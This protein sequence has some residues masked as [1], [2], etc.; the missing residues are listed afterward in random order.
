MMKSKLSFVSYDEIYDLYINKDLSFEE[1]SKIFNVSNSSISRLCKKYGIHKEVI[2]PKRKI[3]KLNRPGKNNKYTKVSKDDLIEYY[4]NQNKTIA[5]VAKILNFAKCVIE[6][7]L[8]FNNIHKTTEDKIK[9]HKQ[10][11]LKKY[12]VDSFSKT[13]EF[14]EKIKQTHLKNCGYESNFQDPAFKERV[15]KQ[16]LEKYGV[17]NV[18][19]LPE[20][21]EKRKQTCLKRYGVDNVIKLKE[22][23]KKAQKTCLKKYGVDSF[24]KTKEFKEKIEATHL[25]NCGETSNFKT[26]EFKKQAEQ[27]CLKKYGVKNAMLLEET[28]RKVFE[29]KKRN[30]TVVTSRFE[31]AV[32]SALLQ[33]FTSVK[34]QYYST[35]YPF[36]CDFYIADIDT[37]IECQGH[38]SHGKE[39][40]DENNPNHQKI[41]ENWK[42][43]NKQTYTDAIRIWTIRD[44]LKRKTA[45]DNHITWLE[46]FN[47]SQFMEWYNA[48]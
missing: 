7:A 40:Y 26:E 11:M 44:P 48:N 43:K 21:R 28:K 45:R 20:I 1:I 31:E 39:P 8:A 36:V 19:Q 24:S 35:N 13:K 47:L 23:R 32:F 2:I 17:E 27:T 41:V 6:R 34:R 3:F 12:G 42:N 9:Q 18:T 16:N 15:I 38:F 5:E 4:I 37:Y 10:I 29:S 30:K 22:F 46:F 25:K 14:K 33:K